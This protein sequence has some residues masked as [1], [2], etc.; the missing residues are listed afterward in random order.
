[1]GTI[2]ARGPKS[3][4][5]AL[6]AGA[7]RSPE[8]PEADDVYGGLVGSWDLDVRYY[9]VDVAAR[10]LKAEMHCTWVLEGRAVQDVW[11]MPV[12]PERKG[13]PQ[14]DLDMYGTTLRVWDPSLRAWRIT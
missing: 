14:K 3:L 1:M 2:E 8:I 5:S 12:R 4:E 11:I 6:F 13:P 7:G 9:W 10:S